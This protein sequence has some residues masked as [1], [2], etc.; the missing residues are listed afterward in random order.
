MFKKR[1]K[2]KSASRYVRTIA[3]LHFATGPEML[4]WA[5][6]TAHWL[7]LWEQLLLTSATDVKARL[8]RTRWRFWAG[9]L[10]PS[11]RAWL[12]VRHLTRSASTVRSSSFARFRAAWR[13]GSR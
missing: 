4:E 8:S 3:H 6:A 9:Q 13:A 10:P 1:R 5:Q 7:W 12:V 11:V 2:V